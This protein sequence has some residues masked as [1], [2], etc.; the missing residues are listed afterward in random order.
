MI[1]AAAAILAATGRPTAIPRQWKAALR[2]SSDG[3]IDGT[4]RCA[5]VRAALKHYPALPMVYGNGGLVL[6]AYE[7]RV[8]R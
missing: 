1:L 8:C 3:R 2:D 4:Y 7:R 6:R 5:V